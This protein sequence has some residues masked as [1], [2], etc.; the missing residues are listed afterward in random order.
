[1]GMLEVAAEAG[2]VEAMKNIAVVYK[3]GIEVEASPGDALKWYLIAEKCGYPTEALSEVTAELRK[4]LKKDQQ[5]K[6]ETEA[7]TWIKAAQAK[8]RVM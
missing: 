7:E 2:N 4:G 1:M 8:N 3:D 6:A 5:K